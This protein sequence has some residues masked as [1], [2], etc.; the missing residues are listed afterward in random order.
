M[1]PTHR[2]PVVLV[3]GVLLALIAG[4][5]NAVALRVSDLGATH[6]TGAVSRSARI[7]APATTPTCSASSRWSPALSPEPFSPA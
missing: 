1:S 5:I 6:V 4:Y 3:G 2:S 7:S